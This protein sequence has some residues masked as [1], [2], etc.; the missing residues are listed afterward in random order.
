MTRPRPGLRCVVLALGIFLAGCGA[1]RLAPHFRGIGAESTADGAVIHVRPG[2]TFG[3]REV[4]GSRRAGLLRSQGVTRDPFA[5]TRDGE[6]VFRTFEVTLDNRSANSIYFNPSDVA[7]RAGPDRRYPRGYTELYRWLSA[8]LSDADFRAMAA[9][10]AETETEV[11]AGERGI[12]LMVFNRIDHDEQRIA[13][14]VT[15]IRIGAGEM[16]LTMS[17][18]RPE[19]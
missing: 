12:W 13:I 14:D 17:F 16:R 19:L 1:K 18:E 11:R 6:V 10:L 2:L 9:L 5:L 15:G 3:V 4:A 7:L 8:S